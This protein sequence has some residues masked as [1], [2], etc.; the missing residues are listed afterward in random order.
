[1]AHLYSIKKQ[2]TS[3][4]NCKKRAVDEAEFNRADV[5]AATD[6]LTSISVAAREA[7]LHRRVERGMRAYGILAR[8]SK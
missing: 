8:T 1:M 4:D 5:I 7:W 3:R 2:R 6:G